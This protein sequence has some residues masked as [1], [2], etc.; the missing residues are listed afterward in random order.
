MN[1]PFPI[2]KYLEIQVVQRLLSSLSRLRIQA[3]RPLLLK[4]YTFFQTVAASSTASLCF[5][6]FDSQSQ[7]KWYHE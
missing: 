1:V 3:A 2:D 4:E 5:R 7:R 6:H